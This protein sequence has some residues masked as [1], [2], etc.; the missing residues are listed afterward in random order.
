[1]NEKEKA[2]KQ[3]L[4]SLK[5]CELNYHAHV[6]EF[7]KLG[8]QEIN[9]WAEQLQDM[10]ADRI[11]R[12]FDEHIKHNSFF[13]TVKDIRQGTADNPRR[14]LGDDWGRSERLEHANKLLADPNTE[15]APAPDRFNEILN[16]LR[17]DVRRRKL[18][19]T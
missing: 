4:I 18:A 12:L 10:K 9:F 13:P 5:K 19:D 16:K 8:Q 3:L 2:Y 11:E 7:G 6:R 14:K 15:R 1:M 17:E